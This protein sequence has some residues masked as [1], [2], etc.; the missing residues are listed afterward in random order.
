MVPGPQ[1]PEE[2]EQ[3][4]RLAVG[5]DPEQAAAA[6]VELVD[7]GDVPV[8][9]P[10]GELVD[11]GRRDPREVPMRQPPPHGHGHRP[12]DVVPGG[13]KDRRD[14]RPAQAL[15]PCREKPRV[16]RRELVLALGPGEGLH[17][18]PAAATL[19]ALP[20]VQEEDRQAPQGHE[21]EAPRRQ[22]VVPGAG[23]LTPRA[24]RLAIGAGT[25]VNLQVQPPGLF[26]EPNGAVHEPGLLLQPIQD[27]LDLHPVLE[28]S[29]EDD[30]FAPPSSQ[31]R[32]RD[33]HRAV[34][35]TRPPTARITNNISGGGA[36]ARAQRAILL[37][38]A[39]S[40]PQPW[41]D[42]YVFT[43]RF[44]GRPGYSCSLVYPLSSLL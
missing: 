18:H 33:A 32:E 21:L 24:P 5:A 19:H 14:G 16:G 15:G 34:P 27:S 40:D 29:C 22:G 9:A 20:G 6:R 36:P 11:A 41:G 12:E 2:A 42:P 8:S 43:H 26:H 37:V 31:S 35:G 3:R 23:P 44:V 7:Q 13:V 39:G 10:A 1:P 4:A 38:D 28:T 25:Q 17:P 30:W